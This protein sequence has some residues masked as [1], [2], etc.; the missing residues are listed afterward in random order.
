MPRFI[1]SAGVLLLVAAGCVIGGAQAQP[2]DVALTT[3]SDSTSAQ[4]AGRGR[5]YRGNRYRGGGHKGGNHG[6]HL[7]SSPC[8]LLLLPSIPQELPDCVYTR[9]RATFTLRSRV[10]KRRAAVPRPPLRARALILFFSPVI[11]ISDNE[12][13]FLFLLLASAVPLLLPAVFL[14]TTTH[15]HG[16][17]LTPPPLLST[18]P[19][20]CMP[21]QAVRSLI[22]VLSTLLLLLLLLLSTRA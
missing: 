2:S 20:P 5:G 15:N 21:P 1:T 10:S 16:P 19:P 17:Q 4:P 8:P 14:N 12:E 6:A 22:I 3:A 11:G 9:V 13:D 7:L 18:P